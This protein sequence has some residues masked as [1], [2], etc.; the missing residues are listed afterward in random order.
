[1]GSDPGWAMLSST[2]DRA[3]ASGWTV[4]EHLLDVAGQGAV[5]SEHAAHDLAYRVM[6]ACPAA[7][8]PAPTPAEMN[9]PAPQSSGR[10]REAA[11]AAI[12][13]PQPP[14]S[15]HTIGR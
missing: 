13:R 15:G 6:D 4:A 9:G 3:Q 14:P 1:L 7:I 2:L 5:N 8:P 12:Q 11:E 10:A